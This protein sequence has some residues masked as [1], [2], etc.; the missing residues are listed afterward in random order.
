MVCDEPQA[1]SRSGRTRIVSAVEARA[2]TVISAI[3]GNREFGKNSP[4]RRR[5]G[6]REHCVEAVGV[7]HGWRWP[8]GSA[9]SASSSGGHALVRST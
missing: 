7:D 8:P 2:G 6:I 3:R 9:G 4:K 1:G 5:S